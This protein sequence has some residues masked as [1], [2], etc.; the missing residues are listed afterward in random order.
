VADN[1]RAP[2]L[3]LFDNTVW[4]RAGGK[5][6]SDPGTAECS[7]RVAVKSQS[8]PR[9]DSPEEGIHSTEQSAIADSKKE[10]ICRT[11]I[12]A[13]PSQEKLQEAIDE[14]KDWWK[15]MKSRFLGPNAPPEEVDLAAFVR[16]AL[17]QGSPTQVAKVLQLVASVLDEVPFKRLL[18]LVDQL[19]LADDEFL[20]TLEGLECAVWQGA[21]YSDIGQARRAWLTY[22]RAI[23]FAQ[24]LGLHRTRNTVLQDLLWHGLFQ[25]DRFSS[26]TLGAPYAVADS[27]CN[28]TFAGNHLPLNLST[29]GFISKLALI[30]GKVIDRT[31]HFLDSSY[32][33]LLETSHELTAMGAQMPR[34]YWDLD[35]PAPKD[36][37]QA[38]LWQEKTIGH[39][40]F[41]Q[42]KLVLHLPYMMK[43]VINTDY[44]YSRDMCFDS[45]R[46][47]LMLFHKMRAPVNARA[48]KCK[49][50]DYTAFMA[51][52]A[53][54]LGLLAYGEAAYDPSR[55]ESDWAIIDTTMDLF[56]VI[57]DKPFGKVASQSYLALQKLTKFRNHGPEAD[58]NVETKVVIPFFGTICVQRGKGYPSS[59]PSAFGGSSASAMGPQVPTQHGPSSY[60]PMEQQNTYMQP[61]PQPPPYDHPSFAF[62]PMPGYIPPTQGWQNVGNFDLD[63]DWAWLMDDL[64][65]PLILHGV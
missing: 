48:N 56:K 17:T 23:T 2:L 6:S 3:S 53:L 14:S 1:G 63:Q 55:G 62:E 39:M 36:M 29:A 47:L 7:P 31:H 4:T 58:Q 9:D 34:D 11:L 21:L 33:T 44:G 51:T 35:H 38:T 59:S 19:V 30:A 43:A 32:T 22:R 54:V 65:P 60:P 27:L 13:I 28:M 57:S 15:G 12:A 64:Q 24:L 8:N 16:K 46:D 10:R 20:G 41:H 37:R 18:L 5:H 52:V 40:I 26:L 50:V 25:A 61:T 49:A 42:T 45:A